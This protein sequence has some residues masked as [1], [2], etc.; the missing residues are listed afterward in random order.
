MKKMFAIIA[1]CLIV[2]AVFATTTESH[3][4]TIQ[5]VV[6][7]QDPAFQLKLNTNQ[8]NPGAVVYTDAAV[9]P[10]ASPIQ[11]PVTDISL[12]DIDVVF[13]AVLANAAKINKS[14][15]IEFK[16]GSFAVTRGGTEGTLAPS[17]DTSKTYVVTKT[18][19]AGLSVAEGTGY[20][21]TVAFNGTTCTSDTALADFH[22]FYAQDT[23]ID[24]NS[25]GYTATVTLE[26][27]TT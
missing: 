10:T 15:T 2:S 18:G 7:S 22:L 3:S 25:D 8:T 27:T 13:Q 1:I 26:I 24:P 11:V 9:Y 6:H 20:K 4:I 23:T 16:P 17:T 5:T 12:G 21:A 14:Y 19:I